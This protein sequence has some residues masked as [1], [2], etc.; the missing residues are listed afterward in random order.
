MMVD[1]RTGPE[2]VLGVPRAL[3]EARV[4]NLR[5]N[6]RAYDFAADEE[7]IIT[8]QNLDK[9]STRRSVVVIT[10]WFAGFSEAN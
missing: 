3:F 10:N 5:L 6:G 4:S 7:G 8:V 2:P 9:D 1:V